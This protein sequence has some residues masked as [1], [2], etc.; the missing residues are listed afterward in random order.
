MLEIK[1]FS[2]SIVEDVASKI[3]D[4]YCKYPETYD[5]KEAGISMI[6]AICAHCPLVE[7]L[8]L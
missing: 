6:D 2:S 7:G 5:E 1:Y 4:H 8:K 3:C